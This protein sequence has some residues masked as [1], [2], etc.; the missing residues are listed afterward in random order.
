MTKIEP[1]LDEV[2][3]SRFG[4][5]M[6]ATVAAFGAVVIAAYA[7]TTEV[8]LRRSLEASADV[9]ESLLG[10]YADPS[11]EPTP[12]APEMLADQLVGMDQPFLITREAGADDMR[13]VYFLSPTMPARRLEGVAASP[14]EIRALLLAEI[15]DRARWRD[16]LLH[17]ASGDF[18]IYVMGSRQSLFTGVLV[19]SLAALVLLPVALWGARRATRRTVAAALGPVTR[20][21]D[22]T[23]GIGPEQLD[24]RLDTPTGQAEATAL[25]EAINEMLARV[26]AAHTQLQAFTADASHELRT[27]LTHLKAQVEWALAEGRSSDAMREALEAIERE[28]E[29]TTK[30]TEDLLLI[31]RGESGQLGF[32][33]SEFDL[34]DVLAEVEEIAAAMAEPKGLTLDVRANGAARVVGDPTRARHALLNLVANAVRYTDRGTITIEVCRT[35]GRCGL[36]VR[37]QGPGVAPEHQELIF[38][39]F[40]RVGHSRSRSQGGAGLGLTIARLFARLQRGEITVTSAAGKGSTFTLWLPAA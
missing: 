18:D 33:S 7:V 25:A 16:R 24:R 5:I 4:R 37:D 28:L 35:P 19:L 27:P 8:Q 31:A 22:V 15:A 20:I 10:L 40:Y 17:R 34:T 39:R 36:A 13:K 23:H 14:E 12:V 6:V 38:D 3:T 29:R 32:A 30:M 2:L 26:D 11:G 9:V 21:A 1:R